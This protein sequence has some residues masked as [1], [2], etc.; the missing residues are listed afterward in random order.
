[1]LNNERGE[2]GIGKEKVGVG[3]ER[4]REREGKGTGI[5]GRRGEGI[6]RRRVGKSVQWMYYGYP[7][8]GS[9]PGRVGSGRV[10]EPN[11][12]LLFSQFDPE[13][14]PNFFNFGSSPS[15]IFLLL[16]SLTDMWP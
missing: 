4:R 3:K 14:N 9:I 8:V 6:E 5:E 15:L 10:P 12:K 13:S 1:V 2:K 7:K 11:Q 16:I